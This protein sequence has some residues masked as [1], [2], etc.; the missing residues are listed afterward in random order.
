MSDLSWTRTII[1]GLIPGGQLYARLFN[2]GGSMDKLWLLLPAFFPPFSLIPMILLKLG[3]ISI[4]QGSGFI[5]PLNKWLLLPIITI[6]MMPFLLDHVFNLDNDSLLGFLITF[7]FIITACSITNIINMRGK[8]KT[9]TFN[10]V[11]KSVMDAIT[12]YG[13]AIFISWCINFIPVIGEIIIEIEMIPF[14][15]PIVKQTIWILG[16]IVGL[17]LLDSFNQI[18]SDICN[19]SWHG[20]K[21]DKFLVGASSGIILLDFII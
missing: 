15:G 11:G 1:L 12:A 13:I 20:T 7:I 6:I 5:N 2:F 10:N 16:Y 18:S 4:K 9:T 17:F 19:I 3:W 14:I 21:T 8:C